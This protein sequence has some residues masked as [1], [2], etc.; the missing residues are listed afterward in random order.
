MKKYVFWTLFVG[1]L[2]GFVGCNGP[3]QEKQQIFSEND[4]AVEVGR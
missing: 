3:K 4:V 2:L 1:G